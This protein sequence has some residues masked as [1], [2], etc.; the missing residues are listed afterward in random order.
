MEHLSEVLKILDGALKSNQ[1][2]AANYA[3]LLADKLE[4]DGSR[5]EARMIRE[6]LARVPGAL[7]IAQGGALAPLKNVH[8]PVD[9]DSRMHTVDLSR[10]NATEINLLLPH[11]LRNRLEDYLD[12]IRH[13]AKLIAAGV[14]IPHRLIMDGPPGTGKTQTARSIAGQLELPLLTVR[15]DT[16]ISSLLG[17]TSRNLRRVFEYAQEFPCVLFLDELDAMATAR[18]S[19]RDV[20]ELQR[21]VISL[22]QN[23][24]ALPVDTI[25]VAATN[26]GQLL[27]YAIW[28]RFSYRLSMP[29]P[30]SQ[31]RQILWKHF[32]GE[33]L[34]EIVD[35]DDIARRSE[36]LSGATIEQVC[37]DAKRTAVLK[38]ETVVDETELFRRLGLT[39]ALGQSKV[40]GSTEGEIRWLRAWY[41]K[42]FTHR[43]LAAAYGTSQRQVRN[44]IEGEQYGYTGDKQSQ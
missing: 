12:G 23:I 35:L 15:C 6:R 17:Q 22:L 31:L 9:G 27:D 11:A 10:P 28:R 26:H 7:S 25:L 34:P 44:A 36:G 13:H 18:G 4:R 2:M 29:L 3:G 21:V 39:L 20:G 1:S 40:V 33:Y 30:D 38:G 32:L 19:E 37:Q 14:A 5:R 43:V 16:M 42:L 41:P 8:L 24:D